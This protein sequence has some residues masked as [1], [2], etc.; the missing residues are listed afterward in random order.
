MTKEKT[1][2]ILGIIIIV[3]PHL[4]FPN[5]LEKIIFAALGA[6]III[7]AYSVHFKKE[8]KVK[9]TPRTATSIQQQTPAPTQT[10][11]KEEITGF[12]YIKKD[13][14]DEAS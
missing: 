9:R 1:L 8:K 12:T 5:G 3:L 6:F 10:L 13:N 7:L 4:G 2:L 11:D 14:G